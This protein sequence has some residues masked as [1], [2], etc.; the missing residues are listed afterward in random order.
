MATDILVLADT[1]DSARAVAQD[2]AD[3]ALYDVD[4]SIGLGYEV[5]SRRGLPAGWHETDLPFHDDADAD[6]D[7]S[8]GDYF[9]AREAEEREAEIEKR[10]M[11]LP[12][13]STGGEEEKK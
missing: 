9:D 4:V 11:L 13:P 5:T 3:D 2:N 8:V 7:I 12:L 6:A 10:Q 1:R